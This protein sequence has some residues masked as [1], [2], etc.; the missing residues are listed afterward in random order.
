MRDGSKEILIED[1]SSQR[2]NET[3]NVEQRLNDLKLKILNLEYIST[4]KNAP[5]NLLEKLGE[6]LVQS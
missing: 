1:E 2:K 3:S 5:P 6:L 4:S